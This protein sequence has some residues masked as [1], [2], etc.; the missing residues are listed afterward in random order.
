MRFA[1]G[2]STKLSVTHGSPASDQNTIVVSQ[3]DRKVKD[4]NFNG[5]ESQKRQ[6]AE[7]RLKERIKR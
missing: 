5:K 6:V 3:I 7:A 1:S 2:T 4:Q